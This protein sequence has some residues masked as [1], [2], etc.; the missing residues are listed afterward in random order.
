MA[1]VNMSGDADLVPITFAMVDGTRLVTA[2]DHKPK[3]TTSLGRLANIRRH[4][5]VTVLADHYDPDEWD[6]LW[7]VRVRGTASVLAPDDPGHAA[8]VA[9][10]V[11]KYVQY[12]GR[13][14]AGAAVV[15]DLH[16][17]RGWAAVTSSDHE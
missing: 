11:A 2:V 3:T 7:W 6:A 1:T 14:P 5:V 16:E 8:A 10:L 9:P 12:A 13:E 4:P 17:V 15:V